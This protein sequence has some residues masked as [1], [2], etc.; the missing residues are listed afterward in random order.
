M[1]KQYSLAL[2]RLES[3]AIEEV[4]LLA[5]VLLVAFHVIGYRESGLQLD[6]PHP[7]RFLADLFANFRMPAFA[8]VAGFVYC[9]RPP[10]QGSLGAFL[11]GKF[12][13]LGVPGLFA[14]LIF[15]EV[16]LALGTRF[17][18]APQDLWQLLVFPYAHYWFLQAILA[19]FVIVGAADVLLRHRGALPLF[20][21]ALLLAIADLPVTSTFSLNFAVILAPFFTFGMCVFRHWRWIVAHGQI[22]SGIAAAVC[23]FALGSALLNYLREPL[24]AVPR[25]I[26][27]S[28]MLGMSICLLMLLHVPHHPLARRIGQFTFTIYLYHV[29]ATSAA[30]M[31]LEQAGVTAIAVH[32][33]VGVAAGLAAPVALHLLLRQSTWTALLALGVRRRDTGKLKPHAVNTAR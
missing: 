18:V 7:L 26:G 10:G 32:L 14:A 5:T 2:E 12:R 9:A 23:V 33:P 19:L 15:A 11:I 22:V 6:Y 1:Q 20:G 28:L 25:G 16:S 31:A 13:R 4:R 21:A 30:R 17:Q 8:F 24:V 29:F 27:A 3:S